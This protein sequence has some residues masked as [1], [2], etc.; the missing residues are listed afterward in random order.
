MAAYYYVDRPGNQVAD[1]PNF[2]SWTKDTFGFS[3]FYAQEDYTQVNYHVNVRDGHARNIRE[4]AAAGTVLLKNNASLPLTGKEQLVS[5]FGSD[6]GENQYGPNGC[7]DRGCDNGTLAMG[8]GSGSAD[9]PYLVTPLEALKRHALDQGSTFESVTDDYA[10]AQITALARRTQ[11][12][13]GPCIVFVNSDSGEE[14]IVVD[15]NV[16]DRNNLT[17]WHNGD[18]LIAN[19]T[20]QC[21]NTI[22][23]MHTVGPVLVTPWYQNPNISAIIWAG[24]PGQE[25]GNAIADILYGDYNPGGKTPFTWGA[26]R[27]SYGTD[28]IYKPNEGSLAPQDDFTEGI[29]IDYRGFDKRGVTPIYEFGYGLSYTTFR[30]S[31]LRVAPRGNQPYRP[32]RGQTPAAPIYGIISNNTQEYVLPANFTPVSA[33]IYPYINSTDLKASSGDS[34]YGSNFSFPAGS[35]S[36]SPQPYLPAGSRNNPGGND[37]LYDVLFTVSADVTNTGKVIGDEVA[38]LYVSLGG[39]NDAVK[40]LRNF[41]RKTIRPGQTVKYDFDI[42][43]R[44]LSNWDTVSQNW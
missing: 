37:G 11:Q 7:P 8:W 20:S 5:V 1:A 42:T 18:D 23:V 32:T 31:N 26:T 29:F 13:R 3:H 35:S 41:D 27:E 33:Y 10:Y 43:R 22:V 44:D 28:I 19:V 34:T 16:G 38:Q 24:I 30:Y 25:S 4:A 40:V 2:S 21:S 15:G 9:F 17:L 12:V 36:G 14:Y 6:A 39:P